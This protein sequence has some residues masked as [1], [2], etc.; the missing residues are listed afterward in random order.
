MRLFTLALLVAPLLALAGC[1]PKPASTTA[2]PTPGDPAVVPIPVDV[3]AVR[4]EQLDEAVNKWKGRPILIDF[5]ATWCAPCVRDFHYTVEAHKKYRDKGL[6]T[7]SVSMDPR[8]EKDKYSNEAVLKFL[9]E[10]DATFPN[11]V[12]LQNVEAEDKLGPRFNKEGGIP[13]VVLLDKS[14]KVAWN[15]EQWA[16]KKMTDAEKHA[17]LE[18]LI[19]AELAK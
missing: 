3:T 5:W 11:Y 1:G 12:L 7:I 4:Y 18:K 19:E 8:G 6:V 16:E 10:S 9:K 13:F 14:G 15:S 17:Q 2:P